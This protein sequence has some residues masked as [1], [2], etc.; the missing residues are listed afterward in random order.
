MNFKKYE[1]GDAV[2]LHSLAR[3]KGISPKLQRPWQ[4]PFLVTHRLNDVLYKIQETQKSKPKVVHSN[5]LKPYVGENQPKFDV[6]EKQTEEINFEITDSAILFEK[7]FENPDIVNF[8]ESEIK[9]F[10]GSE[11]IEELET[12]KSSSSSFKNSINDNC[13]E[14][15]SKRQRKLPNRFAEFIMY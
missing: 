12:D 5:R 2:W 14:I 10:G 7:K 3:K 6:K 15:S 13:K 9:D 8:Q 1:K 4:G 11:N